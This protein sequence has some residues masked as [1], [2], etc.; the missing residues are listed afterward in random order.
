MNRTLS[1]Q[2]LFHFCE[3]FSMILRSGISSAEGLHI[4]YEDSDSPRSREIL[5]S[6][7]RDLEENGRLS[8]TFARS[9]LFPDP[10]IS[11]TK[12]GEETGCL[13]EVMAS[14]ADH[15]E[16]E[17]DISAQIRS[18]VTYPLLML[19]MMGAV[20]V[21]LLV[22]V[23]PVFQQVFRQMGMEMNG[24]SSGLLGA[25]EVISRYSAAF[26]AAAAV[27]IA[28]ILFFCLTSKGK[29][30]LRKGISRIPGLRQIPLAMDYG[31]LTHGIALGIRSGLGPEAS[32][33]FAQMLIEDPRILG[34]AKQADQQLKEG[35]LFSSAITKSGLFQGLEARM[36]SVGFH[37]GAADEVMLRLT[38]RYRESSLA[39]MEKVISVIEPTL[40]ILLSLLVGLILFSVMMPLLGILSEIIA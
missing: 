19:G 37:T 32:L 26:L 31:R 20:I 29:S 11:Y 1:N 18:A 33:K 27:I 16:Q 40:V 30:L 22:K 23:L 14:L 25:G 21:L 5:L 34:R 3:Q 38:D 8:D 12:V 7:S 35:E 6:L 9:G 39:R 15:Y 36:I 28:V 4:L 24:I 10:M 13:D 17:V 2:E